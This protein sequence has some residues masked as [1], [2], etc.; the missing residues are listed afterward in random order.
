MWHGGGTRQALGVLCALPCWAG[1]P[2]MGLASAEGCVCLAC[3][4]RISLLGLPGLRGVPCGDPPPLG[5]CPLGRCQAPC[6]AVTRSRN[7]LPR[8]HPQPAWAGPCSE[9]GGEAEE[10]GSSSWSGRW[11]PA[12]PGAAFLGRRLQ[13]S[14]GACSCHWHLHPGQG[15]GLASGS[16]ARPLAGQ[17][18]QG[19][20]IP[21][22]CPGAGSCALWSWGIGPFSWGTDGGQGGSQGAGGDGRGTRWAGRTAWE[23]S[24]EFVPAPSC[25]EGRGEQ[26]PRGCLAGWGAGGVS[27]HGAEE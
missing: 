17:R 7:L 6:R 2:G 25:W 19:V 23:T 14:A 1:T 26:Q 12:C 5:P 8:C 15:P 16:S 10:A 21:L 24:G 3:Q 4:P 13:C 9:L 27:R 11:L 18:C 20:G 22:T